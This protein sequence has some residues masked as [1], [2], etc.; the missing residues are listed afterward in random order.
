MMIDEVEAGDAEI[1]N[2]IVW[3][4]EYGMGRGAIQRLESRE[5]VMGE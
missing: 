3:E 2:R 4:E 5:K 1:A